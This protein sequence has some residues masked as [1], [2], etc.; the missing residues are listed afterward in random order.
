MPGR[1][2]VAT[3]GAHHAPDL[4]DHAV[5]LE[6]LTVAPAGSAAVVLGDGEVDI[7]PRGDLGQMGD[8]DHLP[9]GRDVAQLLADDRGRVATDP[10]VDLVEDQAPLPVAR[11]ACRRG[12]A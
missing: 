3:G 8:R 5:A 1:G 2:I 6:R 9:A 11:I 4:R 10:G 7:G 12:P